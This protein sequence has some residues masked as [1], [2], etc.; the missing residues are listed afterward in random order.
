MSVSS[1]VITCDSSASANIEFIGR[2]G[3][4]LETTNNATQSNYTIQGWEQYVRIKAVDNATAA[5]YT[6]SQPISILS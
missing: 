5:Y 4:V 2:N 1:N 6:W 3:L